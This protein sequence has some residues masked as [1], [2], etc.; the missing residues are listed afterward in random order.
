M[1]TKASLKRLLLRRVASADAIE[2]EPVGPFRVEVR[3]NATKGTSFDKTKRDL[4]ET[5]RHEGVAG[6]TTTSSS[7]KASRTSRRPPPY[8]VHFI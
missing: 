1:T 3:A 6:S 7:S 8:Q 4:E 2:I 5:L